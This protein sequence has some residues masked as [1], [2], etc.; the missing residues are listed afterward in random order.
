MKETHGKI[1]HSPSERLAETAKS[2]GEEMSDYARD[3]SRMASEQFSRAQDTAV[4]AFDEVEAAIRR[5]PLSAVAIA[6]GVGV[7]LG[8]VLARR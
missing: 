2:L 4:D 8:V 1:P 3:A 7:L 6:L 5:N